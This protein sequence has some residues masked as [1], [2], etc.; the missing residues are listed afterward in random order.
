[1]LED[2]ELSSVL[3]AI[4]YSVISMLDVF[5]RLRDYDNLLDYLSTICNDIEL[6]NTNEKFNVENILVATRELNILELFDEV[7][8]VATGSKT[9]IPAVPRFS[10][11]NSDINH[12]IDSFF[13][14]HPEYSSY[15]VLD[16]SV[17][18]LFSKSLTIGES[19]S[20][21]RT[22]QKRKGDDDDLGPSTIRHV[23]FVLV[24]IMKL[25]RNHEYSDLYDNSDFMDKVD[26]DDSNSDSA[27]FECYFDRMKSSV[28]KKVQIFSKTIDRIDATYQGLLR[29]NG[30][31]VSTMKQSMDIFR[32]KQN[33]VITDLKADSDYCREYLIKKNY[34]ELRSI[35]LSLDKLKKN[36]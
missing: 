34:K 16:E 7:Y 27:L 6:F 32:I 1:M 18:K 10:S 35:V 28:I 19:S 29:K 30:Y 36:I 11:Q 3:F 15:N 21:S 22:L 8:E 26:L 2:E 20:N 33:E 31:Q 13:K 24:N 5:Q 25:L 12:G 9:A 4:T 23:F 17:S 14:E